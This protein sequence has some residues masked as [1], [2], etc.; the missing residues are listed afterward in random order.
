[1]IRGY[2]R[3]PS[4]FRGETLT[5][6]VSTDSP[7]FRV[8][9]FRQGPT[10]TRMADVSSEAL[11]GSFLPD[12]PPDVDWGWTGYEFAIPAEWRSGVYVAML[13]EISDSGRETAPDTTTTFATDA[14]VLFVVL[15]RGSVPFSTF[16]YKISWATF[17]AY[18][19]TMYGSLYS[20]AVW[21]R[22]S[23]PP[24]SRL[25]GGG[26]AAARAAE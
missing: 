16:L 26:L 1:M 19:A 23:S 25:P 12:G 8:E 9:F 5:L 17:V 10:L 7:R 2:P 20:E 18:N 14:K 4:V 3:N 11:E 6:H 22:N 24:D 13:I 21:S 15:H